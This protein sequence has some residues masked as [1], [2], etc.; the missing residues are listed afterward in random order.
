[1]FQGRVSFGRATLEAFR[2]GRAAIQS[3]RERGML[4]ELAAQPARLRSE[5]QSL[6]SAD[7]LRHFRSRVQPSFFPGFELGKNARHDPGTSGS[8]SCAQ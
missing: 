7:L 8:A 6:S 1:M 3:S 5:F 4:D 2:R